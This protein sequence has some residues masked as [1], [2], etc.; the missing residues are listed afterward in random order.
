[1]EPDII[2]ADTRMR[3]ITVLVV[4]MATA[5]AAACVLGFQRWLVAHATGISPW[6]LVAELRQWIAIAM[7][8]TSMCFLLL[9]GHAARLARRVGQSGR[10]PLPGA[11]PLR[12]TRIR[13]G[14][15]ARRIAR[16]LNASAI[17]SIALAAAAIAIGARL[18]ML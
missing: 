17:L 13:R 9:A 10:W 18:S 7:V 12:D 15:A 11:R 6:Q 5:A 8:A 3:A 1:M 2:Q 16:W 14:D 4:L